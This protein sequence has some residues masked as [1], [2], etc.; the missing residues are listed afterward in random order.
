MSWGRQVEGE[1][2]MKTTLVCDSVVWGRR[3]YSVGGI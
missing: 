1:G 2:G 3:C